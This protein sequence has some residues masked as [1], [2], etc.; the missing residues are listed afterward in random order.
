MINKQKEKIKKQLAEFLGVGVEDIETQDS[1][2]NDL[3]MSPTDITDFLQTLE[4]DGY[5]ID[6]LDLNKI[7]TL[8]ELTDSLIQEEE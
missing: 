1:L 2:T 3:H 4:S 6:K 5:N 7:E 8:D